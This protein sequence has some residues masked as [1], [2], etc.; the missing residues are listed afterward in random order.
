M[1]NQKQTLNPLQVHFIQLL[2]QWELKEED[3]NEIKSMVSR[4]FA[5]KADRLMEHIW[6]EKNL[7]Q[8]DLDALISCS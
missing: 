2:G 5:S 4:H 3:L 8:S 1:H 7:S 6:K